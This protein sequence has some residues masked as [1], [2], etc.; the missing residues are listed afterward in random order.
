MALVFGLVFSVLSPASPA[1]AGHGVSLEA[2]VEIIGTA[3]AP[4]AKLSIA[5]V[6]TSSNDTLPTVYIRTPDGVDL[7]PTAVPRGAMSSSTGPSYVREQTFTLTNLLP[8]NSGGVVYPAGVYRVGI[9]S[10]CGCRAGAVNVLG[11]A[12]VSFEVGFW[13][14]PADPL[15]YKGSPSFNAALLQNVAG[16]SAFSQDLGGFSPNGFG[17]EYSF[18]EDTRTTTSAMKNDRGLLPGDATQQGLPN[19][20]GAPV[21]L[22]GLAANESATG[23]RYHV[24]WKSKINADIASF[25]GS[26]LTM[27]SDVTQALAPAS[28][29]AR[30]S[31]K[32]LLVE[33]DSDGLIRGWVTR[34]VGFSLQRSTNVAPT[35]TVE[36]GGVALVNGETIT[37]QAGDGAS[38][39]VF[40]DDF[41]AN[42][43]RSGEAVTLSIQNAPS[44][45]TFG[46][47]SGTNRTTR[48]LALAPGEA[49]AP[50]SRIVIITAR[51]NNSFAL[52][53]QFQF[54]LTIGTPPPAI[55]SV[56][57]GQVSLSWSAA[58]GDNI[59]GYVLRYRP[60]PGSGAFTTLPQLSAGTL[61]RIVTGLSNDQ[62]YVF[63]LAVVTQ[64]SGGPEVVGDF[65]A[66]SA[67]A[68]PVG[69]VVVE[70][71]VPDAAPA[72]GPAPGPAPAPALPV[73]VVPLVT[74]DPARAL[75]RLV[76]PPSPVAGPVLRP[77][78]LAPAPLQPTATLGGSP[79]LVQ[80]QITDPNTMSLRSGVLNIAVNIG[81][82]QGAI[83][84]QNGAGASELEVRTG[85]NTVFGGSG[86]LPRSSV[87]VFMPLQGTN[88]REIARIPVDETGSFSGNAL[89]GALP[90]ER[91]LPIGRQ[92]LQIVSVDQNGQ[93]A[94]MEMAINIAQSV[95][96]PELDRSQGAVPALGPG[97]MLAT[98]GGDPEVV[99]VTSQADQKQASIQGDTW[100]MSVALAGQSAGAVG[101]SAEGTVLVE[102]IRNE[103]AQISGAG[104]MPGSRADVW[105][106]STPTLL[107]SVTIDANGEFNG[108]VNIDGNVVSVGEH[109][110][111]LQGVGTD[112]FVRAA[113]LGVVV[114]DA[115][116]E[117]TIEEAAGF[118]WWLWL[119]VALGVVALGAGGTW[120]YRKQSR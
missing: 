53:S 74:P 19:S 59:V 118:L 12:R 84:Q 3:E 93:Q 55:A 10:T 88:S 35:I 52:T 48:V 102:F 25:S 103:R 36:R 42:G 110:L 49:E 46:T 91:P 27:A 67:V 56:A 1:F 108:E 6:W 5:D 80:T 38:L 81:A 71:T 113:N 33:K 76:L 79:A 9:D 61:A 69:E 119:M 29:S 72:P 89:F 92:V 87:Q 78:A 65:S 99:T 112:G 106:F 22:V 62:G 58:S 50:S 104:F 75:P 77:N 66:S 95:P 68:T 51:D 64:E 26:V 21:T 11:E 4:Q 63:Q 43:D 101:E 96:A 116:V 54:R 30:L 109:T 14:D 44:W 120:W 28:G 97:Q 90:S 37:L 16:G 85:G 83:R 2:K 117:A 100:S 31:I 107:G 13:F 18:L 23:T 105:L 32:V 20:D 70:P 34:D 17:V 45:A 114:N 98:N 111:Q 24:D 39:S 86:L 40:G 41:D 94:V 60:S 15:G 7:N 82:D 73:E 57:G 115:V 47:A 8:A